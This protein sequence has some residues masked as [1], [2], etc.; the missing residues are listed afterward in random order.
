MKE[1]ALLLTSIRRWMI[2]FIVALTLSGLTAFPIE[3]ELAW[4]CSWWPEHNSALY[5]WLLKNYNAIKDTNSRYPSLSYGYDWLA[6]AHIVIAV[7][8]IGPYKDP[9]RNIFVIKFG[10]IACLLIV[11]LALLAGHI[12][13][14]PW[15]WRLIDISFGVFGSVPLFICYNKA[16]AMEKLSPAYES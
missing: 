15:Y 8:F 9:V 11:P 5:H 14:I 1:T 6:F 16:R 3:S 2:F 13:G 7:A 12:R 4:V 10:L